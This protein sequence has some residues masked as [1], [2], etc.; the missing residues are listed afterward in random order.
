M[1]TGQY[2]QQQAAKDRPYWVYV[3][4]GDISGGGVFGA[5][6]GWVRYDAGVPGRRVDLT[7]ERSVVTCIANCNPPRGTVP[8]TPIYKY[9]KEQIQNEIPNNDGRP[10]SVTAFVPAGLPGKTG[11]ISSFFPPIKVEV[12]CQQSPLRI[13]GGQIPTIY[14]ITIR[15]NGVIK[16]FGTDKIIVPFSVETT[17]RGPGPIT[18]YT[19]SQYTYGNNQKDLR[20]NVYYSNKNNQLGDFRKNFRLSMSTLIGG[21]QNMTLEGDQYFFDVDQVVMTNLV[22]ADGLTDQCGTSACDIGFEVVL[23]SQD[24]SDNSY[25]DYSTATLQ[26]PVGRLAIE[27]GVQTGNEV[28]AYSEDNSIKQ[29]VYQAFSSDGSSIPGETITE[30]RFID[31]N[32][33]YS[34]NGSLPGCFIESPETCNVRISDRS[35]ILLDQTYFGRPDIQTS[36]EYIDING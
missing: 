28:V 26:F 1:S 17:L 22:R 34:V 35:G 32:C 24:D 9:E 15:A 6:G 31:R 2:T 19:V 20:A 36:S 25:T 10:P 8:V 3:W 13:E 27:P 33:T 18:G 29:T 7:R 21:G 5:E 14:D 12:D 30:V 16:E 4:Q 11:A 23:V